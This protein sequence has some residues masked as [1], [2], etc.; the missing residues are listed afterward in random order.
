MAPKYTQNVHNVTYW[1]LLY[2]NLELG[3]IGEL[4]LLG[5][6]VEGGGEVGEGPAQLLFLLKGV[7]HVRISHSL[8][9]TTF[10]S[11]VLC[12]TD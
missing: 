11:G 4:L 3:R 5:E 10:L 6:L 1:V 7:L 2:S 8:G 9:R 12:C